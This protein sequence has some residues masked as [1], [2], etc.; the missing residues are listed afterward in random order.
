MEDGGS[1]CQELFFERKRVRGIAKKGK[2]KKKASSRSTT[3]VN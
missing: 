2:E 1:T 3:L